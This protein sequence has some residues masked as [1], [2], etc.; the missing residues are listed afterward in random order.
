MGSVVADPA[1]ESGIWRASAGDHGVDDCN[2]ASVVVCPILHFLRR[3]S[4]GKSDGGSKVVVINSSN[5]IT[6]TRG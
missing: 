5:I 1:S 6:N 4:R 3:P 2:E